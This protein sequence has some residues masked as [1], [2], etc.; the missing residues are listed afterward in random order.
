MRLFAAT[1]VGLLL[2]SERALA[3]ELSLSWNAPSG[4]PRLHDLQAGLETRQKRPIKLGPGAPQ[5]L[6]ANVVRER[7]GFRLV[8]VTHTE[9]GDA[10][11]ELYTKSCNELARATLLVA[12]LLLSTP[13]VPASRDEPAQRARPSPS[14]RVSWHA[15]LAGVLTV[16]RLAAFAP[17]VTA[18]LG[19]EIAALSVRLGALYL[20]P[21]AV[22]VEQAPGA[23]VVLQLMAAEASLCY[24]WTRTPRLASCAYA[25]IGALRAAGR[26]LAQDERSASL[27]LAGALG[28][29]LNVPLAAWL[30][31]E[32]ALSLGVP[33]QRTQLATRDLGLVYRVSA[34]YGQLQAG[35]CVHFP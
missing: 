20:A 19:L 33:F 10:R 13:P 11:R 25:E 30:E 24:G 23:Q 16:G 9:S 34:L 32:A 8:L 18:K 28:L 2:F 27:W 7:D 35:L 6:D 21:R 29:Q 14:A 26:G 12:S 4:C 3:N 1:L 22:T 31:L 15:T 5:T 17:G